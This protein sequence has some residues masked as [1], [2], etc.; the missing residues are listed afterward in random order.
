MRTNR[1]AQSDV[2]EASVDEGHD[3]VQ[4]LRAG[5][6]TR[7]AVEGVEAG[8]QRILRRSSGGV[9]DR[10]TDNP[11]ATRRPRS[12]SSNG[13]VGRCSAINSEHSNRTCWP[14]SGVGLPPSS[15]SI[16]LR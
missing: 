15:R 2:R 5:A 1:V 13:I 14:V 10:G 12:G 9:A 6:W 8:H 4:N 3:L 11:S 16:S 7:T